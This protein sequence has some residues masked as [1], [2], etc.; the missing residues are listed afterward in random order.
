MIHTID[1]KLFQ[2]RYLNPF[3]THHTHLFIDKKDIKNQIKYI[4]Y[5]NKFSLF[6]IDIHFYSLIVIINSVFT[7]EKPTIVYFSSR[8]INTFTPNLNKFGYLSH[9]CDK[10]A[11]KNHLLL[12]YKPRWYMEEFI[13]F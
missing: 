5:H 12:W 7:A 9:H 10:N 8:Y 13:H 1:I 4:F 3:F 6:S 2:T 11:D